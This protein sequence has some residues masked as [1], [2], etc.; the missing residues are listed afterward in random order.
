MQAT[1]RIDLGAAF[2]SLPLG[3]GHSGRSL[4]RVSVSA[5]YK[6]TKA[7][8]RTVTS[9]SD[10]CLDQVWPGAWGRMRYYR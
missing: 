1:E 7:G 5:V 9:P 3:L 8:T 10:L 2:S 6:T 4:L